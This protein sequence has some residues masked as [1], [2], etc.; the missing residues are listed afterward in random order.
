MKPVGVDHRPPFVTPLPEGMIPRQS[1]QHA[2]ELRGRE[3]GDVQDA[4]ISDQERVLN[5]R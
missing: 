2:R 5:L 1:D 3:D 4:E